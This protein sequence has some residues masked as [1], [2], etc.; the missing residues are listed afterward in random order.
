MEANFFF[1]FAFS[2][3]KVGKID[4][5]L[6]ISPSR[7]FIISSFFSSSSPFSIL[8]SIF[9]LYSCFLKF[10]FLE[11]FF[12]VT[13]MIL[14]PFFFISWSLSSLQVIPSMILFLLYRLKLSMKGISLSMSPLLSRL[15]SI[16]SLKKE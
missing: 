10:Y 14:R 15:P 4:L 3:S 7:A 1:A 6:I 16:I 2:Y 11:I 9:R 8:S 13:V 12:K 5:W